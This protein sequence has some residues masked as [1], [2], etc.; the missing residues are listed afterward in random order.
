MFI[1]HIY[2]NQHFIILVRHRFPTFLL[3]STKWQYEQH[4]GLSE[5]LATYFF[6]SQRNLL[7]YEE[8]S[9][10]RRAIHNKSCQA[11]FRHKWGWL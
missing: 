4:D 9:C 8:Q 5:L 7:K 10:F 1:T 11:T 2:K 6:L 3:S